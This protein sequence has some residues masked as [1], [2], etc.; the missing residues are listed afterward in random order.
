MNFKKI[1]IIKFRHIN[2]TIILNGLLWSLYFSKFYLNH[3]RKND[4]TEM[5]SVL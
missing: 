4:G 5:L 1:I 3:W 2:F